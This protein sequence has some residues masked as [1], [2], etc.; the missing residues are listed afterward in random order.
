MSIEL[1]A[2]LS[3]IEEVKWKWCINRKLKKHGE[4]DDYTK[5]KGSGYA[6]AM[7]DY[8][9]KDFIKIKYYVEECKKTSLT[10]K[11]IIKDIKSI[12]SYRDKIYN[13]C[14]YSYWN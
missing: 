14:G 11:Q 5:Q 10:A 7:Y 3:H 2:N 4:L 13:L 12:A 8:A 6:K 1:G 9:N